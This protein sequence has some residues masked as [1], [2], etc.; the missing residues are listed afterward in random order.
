MDSQLEEEHQEF[1][2]GKSIIDAIFTKQKWEKL[3]LALFDIQ[4]AYDTVKREI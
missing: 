4:K 2:L 1:R 3:I